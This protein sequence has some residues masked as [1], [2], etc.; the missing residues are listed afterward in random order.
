MC[1]FV[2]TD[3]EKHNI[4]DDK[5]KI[6][7]NICETTK[8]KPIKVYS[9][10]RGIQVI[11]MIGKN[12]PIVVKRSSIDEHGQMNCDFIREV[13]ILKNLLKI[14]HMFN[15][16][17]P[18]KNTAEQYAAKKQLE[19]I[20]LPNSIF[21]DK[22]KVTD[23]ISMHYD[24]AQG[25]LVGF[26][27]EVVKNSEIASLAVQNYVKILTS[28]RN[29]TNLLETMGYIYPDLKPGNI[30]YKTSKKSL[31][32][33]LTD[34]NTTFHKSRPLTAQYSTF[35]TMSPMYEKFVSEIYNTLNSNA[36]IIKEKQKVPINFIIPSYDVKS[37]AWSHGCMAYYFLSGG[38]FPINVS[39]IND[40]K[41][42]LQKI[43]LVEITKNINTDHINAK[44]IFHVKTAQFLRIKCHDMKINTGE[45][46]KIL[47]NENNIEFINFKVQR[48][49]GTEMDW[50]ANILLSVLSTASVITIDYETALR[51]S[52]TAHDITEKY[53][54]NIIFCEEITLNYNNSN[55]NF[56]FNS[57]ADSN[58][59]I[60]HNIFRILKIIV[61]NFSLRFYCNNVPH[62]QHFYDA[63]YAYI[64]QEPF[65]ISHNILKNI[66]DHLIRTRSLR[67]IVNLSIESTD[68]VIP[69]YMHMTYI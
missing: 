58:L 65:G 50:L 59:K 67:K 4:C 56:N 38:K 44:D 49:S 51:V 36:K 69:D 3:K 61:L 62:I 52:Q 1:F 26:M 41:N 5:C 9:I 45:H 53:A 27:E 30:L 13:D 25:D 18:K 24:K 6:Q 43:D 29:A 31:Q 33:K 46:N 14:N 7:Q 28:I 66:S 12:G 42:I 15:S 21:V 2:T 17:T 22:T 23:Y 55:P 34:F 20:M 64:L 11:C 10:W 63:V 39:N 40:Y 54:N 60:R 16:N 57:D 8:L 32:I 35:G 19:N 37:D 47:K 68:P 48:R